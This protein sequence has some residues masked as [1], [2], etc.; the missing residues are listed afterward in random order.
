MPNHGKRAIVRCRDDQYLRAIPE[1]RRPPVRRALHLDG[2]QS[3]A[4][5]YYAKACREAGILTSL[6]GGGGAL[7][8]RRAPEIH[9]RCH[10]GGALLRADG[11][12]RAADASSYLQAQRLPRRRRHAR[13]A[14]PAVVRRKTVPSRTTPA[15]P[16]PKE[17]RHRHQRRGRR[18]PR[19]LYLFLSEP[20]RK[21]SGK[22]ISTSPGAPRPSRSSISATKPACRPRRI[23]RTSS[24]SSAIRCWK[25]ARPGRTPRRCG[26]GCR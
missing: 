22:S 15:L 12:D 25:P 10:R 20:I 5:M 19:R 26:K 6:D 11:H 14:R 8:H 18:V 7:E 16:V 21:R 9:R 24:A 13:R 17:K 3:D 1:A 4:A 23:S 2:H